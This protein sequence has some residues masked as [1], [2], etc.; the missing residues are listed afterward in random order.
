E[1]LAGTV[2]QR[3]TLITLILA[4]AMPAILALGPALQTGSGVEMTLA[5][6]YNGFF[7]GGQWI[8]VQIN[9]TNLGNDITGEVRVRT[10]DL[11]SLAGTTY[12]TPLDLPRGS[13][14]QVF[15]YVSLD[16]FSRD[17]Q[18]ELVDGAGN[19]VRRGSTRVRVVDQGDVLYAVITGSPLGPVE[20]TGVQ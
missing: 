3:M 8:P 15:L 20:L 19:I 2:K 13:R 9:V 7:R 5:A 18:V 12:S 17:L 16:G 10:G 14:K 1:T 11:S 4:L 6:G